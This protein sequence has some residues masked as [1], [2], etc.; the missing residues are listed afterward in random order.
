MSIIY[1]IASTK[2]I[3]EVE[4]Q[5]DYR[6][7]L[8]KS[9]TFSDD[10]VKR[11]F[12][13]SYDSVRN[14]TFYTLKRDKLATIT[15]MKRYIEDKPSEIIEMTIVK[16]KGIDSLISSF[17]VLLHDYNNL[18]RLA[19]RKADSL[20]LSKV[21]LELIKK[22]YDI[23]YRVESDKDKIKLYLLSDKADSAFV[24]LRYYRDRIQYDTNQKCWL[25]IKDRTISKQKKR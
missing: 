13:I 19:N 20:E 16:E 3:K 18:V 1:N 21:A 2:Y 22:N 7:S 9:M 4:V 15:S 6:D 23:T 24:L 14:E 12:D 11:Y 17:D 25:I 8:I 10:L 5:I